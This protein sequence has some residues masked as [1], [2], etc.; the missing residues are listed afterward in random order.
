MSDIIVAVNPTAESAAALRFAHRLAAAGHHRVVAMHV[1]VNPSTEHTP[2]QEQIYLQSVRERL[3]EWLPVA[4]AE[5]TE[6]VTVDGDITGAVVAEAE[7]RDARAVVV[8]SAA[9]EGVSALGFGSLVH[10]LA[11]HL[12]CPLVTVPIGASGRHADEIV[13]GIDGSEA[14]EVALH[15]TSTL[16]RELGRG[17][18]AVYSVD[19]IYST[20]TS[21]GY[22]G[23][24]EQLARAEAGRAPLAVCF[25]ERQGHHPSDVLADVARERHAALIVVSAREHH[26]LG[27][28]LLGGVPD[29]LLHHPPC[30]VMVLPLAYIRQ[31]ELDGENGL[32]VS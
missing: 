20:F 9:F 23:A 17:V 13:V 30:P 2:A 22:L 31:Q 21:H 8:G 3:L 10:K 4:D 1:S 27:G 18:C 14:S 29:H 11:H 16:A 5:R 32:T 24:K 25:V 19:D 28:T 7:Q 12:T 26:A 15:L 6:L